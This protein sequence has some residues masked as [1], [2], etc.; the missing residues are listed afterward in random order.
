MSSDI[1]FNSTGLVLNIN[2]VEP[3]S[4]IIDLQSNP[5]D[6]IDS[7]PITSSKNIIIDDSIDSNKVI[8]SKVKTTT[9]KYIKRNKTDDIITYEFFKACINP[10]FQSETKRKIRK[11][12]IYKNQLVNTLKMLNLPFNK[13]DKKEQMEITLFSFYKKLASID[14]SNIVKAINLYKTNFKNKIK[15]KKTKLYG[16]GFVDKTICKNQEDCFS[17]ELIDDIED[18]YFFSIK[19][20][21]DSI[22]FFDIRTFNKLIKTKSKNPYTR[23]EFNKESLYLFEYRKQFMEKNN[24]SIIYK[25]EQDYLDNLTPQDKIKNR[26]FDIFQ[27]IDQLNTMAGGTR[28]E[29]FQNLNIQQLKQYYKVLEDIWNYRAN[30][31]AQQKE[32]IVPNNDMF[33]YSVNYIFCQN[34]VIKIQNIIL[35]EMEKLIHSSPDMN[36]RNTGAYYILIA[37]T[38]VSIECAQD[39]PWL[40][41][42]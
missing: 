31:S 24:I 12:F 14:N 38:E 2:Q 41:Q 36:N 27:T 42:Y 16:P 6:N 20:D 5:S 34:N 26:I 13:T 3:L 21:H 37:F 23:E 28:I 35:T 9:R 22:F 39:M 15:Q 7:G 30:L 8:D 19:D 1:P 4:D 25:E 29:W 17:M 11:P 18:K 40:I 33:P 32:N 10:I